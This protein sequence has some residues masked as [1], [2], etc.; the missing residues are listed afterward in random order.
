[1]ELR[2]FC[3]HDRYDVISW[4]YC[5][6]R[7]YNQYIEANII[8]KHCGKHL[9]KEIKGDLCKAFETAY[10]DKYGGNA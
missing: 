10:E 9:T 4:K 5:N 2:L 3:K 7:K 8:C 6:V 1:M